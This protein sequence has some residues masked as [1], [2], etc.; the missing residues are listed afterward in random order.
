MC[1]QKSALV[2]VAQ[3]P[4]SGHWRHNWLKIKRKSWKELGNEK[5]ISLDTKAREAT[6]KRKLKPEGL[7]LRWSSMTSAAGNWEAR[8]SV[9]WLSQRL[10]SQEK[11]ECYHILDLV[12]LGCDS[13]IPIHQTPV[14]P[15]IYFKSIAWLQ[16]YFLKDHH[17]NNAFVLDTD[18]SAEI[19]SLSLCG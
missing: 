8:F 13:S 14:L 19:Q 7:W 16:F 18:C 2:I 1:K 5:K 17:W 11:E 12:R 10:H 9:Q 15:F 4:I 6:R 3:R